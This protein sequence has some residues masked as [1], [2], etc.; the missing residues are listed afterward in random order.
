MPDSLLFGE[1]VR[2]NWT[3]PYWL[4]AV[5]ISF[6]LLI[7]LAIAGAGYVL[8]FVPGLNK[9][10]EQRSTRVLLA[11]GLTVLVCIV[12]V[13]IYW[14]PAYADWTGTS[15]HLGAY[16]PHLEI[17]EAAANQPG[18]RAL[19]LS[20]LLLSVFI[21]LGWLTLFALCSRKIMS[22]ISTV[23]TEGPMGWFLWV[24]GHFVFIVALGGIIAQRP[25]LLAGTLT[26]LADTGVSQ[27]QKFEIESGVEGGHE[28]EVGFDG[29]QLYAMEVWSDQSIEFQSTRFVD[30]SSGD[31]KIEEALEGM[32]I[33]DINVKL[34]V[35]NP[36]RP[37]RLMR[38]GIRDEVIPRD[39]FIDKLYVKNESGETA[40]L[41]M[42]VVTSPVIR[43][44]DI[45][46]PAKVLE[47][48]PWC[49][50]STVFV[51]LTYF[52]FRGVTP[53]ISAV[54]LSTFKTEVS[55]PVYIILLIAGSIIVCAF[56]IFPY[57]T[58]GEDIKMLKDSGLTLILVF[59]I[60]LAIW[61]ASKSVSEEIEGRTAL[62]VLSKP[63]GRRQ[64]IIGKFTGI[65]WAL[66]VFVAIVGV[67]VFLP[68]VSFKAVY[69]AQ[70]A[71]L[72]APTWQVCF[73]EAA[74]IAPGLLLGFM[75]ALIFVA[76][77]VTI[78]TRLPMMSNILICFAIYAL[79]HLTP[80]MV[81]NAA[82]ANVVNASQIVEFFAILVSLVLPMLD[83]F[84]IQ[85]A[86]T[87]DSVVPLAYLGWSLVYCAI[88]GGIALLL[89]LIFFED[90]DV[91]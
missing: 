43:A 57:N 66:A 11:I 60:F 90:R 64:F 76:I 51:F 83:H 63:I 77:S 14:V 39:Q 15:H 48:L 18:T 84:N 35:E 12:L 19:I 20:I 29:D 37:F 32:R 62:T 1:I 80:L 82:V 36:P 75:E 8:S 47:A 79:G 73:S 49:V 69:D 30:E 6:G 74:K 21:F 54:A 3:T 91:G 46:Y 55:Q 24:G 41:E 78:S 31:L 81:Q 71:S 87:S 16:Q 7:C 56:V 4:I 40:T 53:K 52:F 65:A 38:E 88:Y 9:I 34:E 28:I 50:Y 27:V 45:S 44:G 2:T 58:F 23:M 59:S 25:M 68:A 86:I 61:S 5:G 17:D 13:P 85:A 33:Q 70:E 42:R 22:E 10:N 72:Q 26:Q 89:G 67:A